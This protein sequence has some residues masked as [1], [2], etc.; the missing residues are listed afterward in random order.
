MQ[1]TCAS[2]L[3]S[4]PFEKFSEGGT[5]LSYKATL[6]QLLIQEHSGVS[7]EYPVY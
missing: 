6:A 5:L 1:E 3:F 4:I 2:A 7:T